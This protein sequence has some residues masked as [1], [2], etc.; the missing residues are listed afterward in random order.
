MDLNYYFDKIFNIFSSSINAGNKK[1]NTELIRANV[2][3]SCYLSGEDSPYFKY[4]LEKENERKQNLM[5]IHQE[6]FRRKL[7]YASMAL[8][9][10]NMVKS[11]M[12]R[13]GYFAHFFYHTRFMSL[14]IYLISVYLIKKHYD[15]QLMNDGL[16]RY[17]TKRTK[18]EIIDEKVNKE[19]V[20]QQI[21]GEKLNSGAL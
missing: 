20:K 9:S 17:K 8:I 11:I 2:E 4:F 7:T 16:Y 6:L 14:G 12:W 19:I 3:I 5:I 18:Y 15:L 13:Y 10:Y 1:V 21:I